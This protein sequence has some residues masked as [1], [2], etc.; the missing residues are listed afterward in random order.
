MS[1]I[2]VVGGG[3]WW[4]LSQWQQQW[5]YHWLLRLLLPRTTHEFQTVVDPFLPLLLLSFPPSF[6]R[7][8]HHSPPLLCFHPDKT[9]TVSVQQTTTTNHHHKPPP[10]Q[11]LPY[12][13]HFRSVNGIA[14]SWILFSG[15]GFFFLAVGIFFVHN[16]LVRHGRQHAGPRLVHQTGV[17]LAAIHSCWWWWWWG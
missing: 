2:V 3:W 7:N 11:G 15:Q 8:R 4:L 6:L 17:M 14:Q 9:T 10:L 5:T 1:V 13:Q 12:Q 16:H